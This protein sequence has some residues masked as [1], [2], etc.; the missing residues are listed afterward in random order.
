[1]LTKMGLGAGVASF[2]PPPFAFLFHAHCNAAAQTS[3]MPIATHTSATVHR[4]EYVR[5]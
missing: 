5:V 1:M 2:A 3:T 4:F